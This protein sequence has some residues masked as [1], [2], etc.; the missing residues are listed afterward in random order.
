MEYRD[1][2]DIALILLEDSLDYH[3]PALI[4][5]ICRRAGLAED[6]QSSDEDTFERVL[7]RAI[8]ILKEGL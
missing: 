4:T 3:D 6:Y 2:E 1:Y 7:D 5:E 8:E